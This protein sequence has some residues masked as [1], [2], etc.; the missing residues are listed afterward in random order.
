M[1]CSDL[2][3]C[4]QNS[5]PSMAYSLIFSKLTWWRHQ[6]ETFS[7]LLAICT[8]NS[9]VPVNSPHKGQW[10]GALTVTLICAWINGWL[11]NRETGDLRRH[12]IHYDVIVM[13]W[14]NSKCASSGLMWHLWYRPLT[15]LI[16]GTDCR[17]SIISPLYRIALPMWSRSSNINIV[18][19]MGHIAWYLL[20]WIIF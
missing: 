20:P 3:L 16:Q 17:G 19:W 10:R 5:S 8:G 13:I 12:R 6:M 9:T 2:N 4:D 14:R 15:R 1:S 18:Y 11:N 7:A